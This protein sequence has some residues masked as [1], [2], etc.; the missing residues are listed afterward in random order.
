MNVLEAIHSR[1]SSGNVRPE[2]IPR[3]SIEQ[4]I[5]AATRAPNHRLTQPWRFFV[6]AGEARLALGRA[7]AQAQI[8][9]EAT[10]PDQ[11]AAIEEAARKKVLRGPVIVTVAIDPDPNPKVVEVEEICAGAAA[12]QN[13]LLAAHALGL[14]AI[15]RTGDACTAAEVK[16]VFG[17][18]PRTSLLGFIYVGYPAAAAAPRE[19]RSGGELTTWLGW[20]G[21]PSEPSAGS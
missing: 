2:P 13:M 10:L 21:S 4:L 15:W 17:L 6:M 1:R 8:R 18:S 7:M 12:I 14:A 16:E 5:D 20:E 3:D 9:R 11:I 19:R